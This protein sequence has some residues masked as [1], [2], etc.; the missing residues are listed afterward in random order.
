MKLLKIYIFFI[1]IILIFSITTRYISEIYNKKISENTANK[2]M[3]KPTLNT[4]II[5]FYIIILSI[6]SLFCTGVICIS[7]D[8][9]IKRWK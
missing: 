8:K 3:I 4:H 1:I 6:S 9:K 5:T 7:M 2:Y